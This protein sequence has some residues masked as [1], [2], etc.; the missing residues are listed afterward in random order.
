MSL[1]KNKISQFFLETRSGAGGDDAKDFAL[2]L[3][4]MYEKFFTKSQ[5]KFEIINDNCLKVFLDIKFLY[6]ENGIHKL[7]RFSP[8][9]KI[10][11]RQTSFAN[12]FIYPYLESDKVKINFSDLEITSLKAS[13]PGGQ[14]VNKTESAIRIKHIPTGIIIV[15]RFSK[16]QNE[17]RKLA[18]DLLVSK[19]EVL[20]DKEK[21]EVLSKYEVTEHFRTYTLHPKQMVKDDKLNIIR[22]N[23]LE[24]LE[25]KLDDF[26]KL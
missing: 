2:M 21:K 8:F 4:K 14:H 1:E 22:Y 13:G 16:S 10:E 15:S 11:S 3:K 6:K 25:G 19:L 17:N 26:I 24:I 12:V 9:K 18:M 5:I 23:A 7:I 20:K